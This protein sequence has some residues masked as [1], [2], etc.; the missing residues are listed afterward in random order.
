MYVCVKMYW[1][2]KGAIT[3]KSP[4]YL[5]SRSRNRTLNTKK[6]PP[7]ILA[8]ALRSFPCSCGV[9]GGGPLEKQRSQNRYHQGSACL[10]LELCG[11]GS[12]ELQVIS[13]SFSSLISEWNIVLQ[14]KWDAPW[15]NIKS[16][17]CI[18]GGAKAQKLLL[19]S[20]QSISGQM[21]GIVEMEPWH[22]ALPVLELCVIP[23]RASPGS[24]F[25]QEVVIAA[26]DVS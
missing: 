13:E 25:S 9:E 18:R 26:S 11:P 24:Q 5:P 2:F 23:G 4:L 8:S 12:W 17:V 1:T 21:E 10:A 19:L 7:C 15:I 6:H 14:N 20:W 22:L 16:D 3:N